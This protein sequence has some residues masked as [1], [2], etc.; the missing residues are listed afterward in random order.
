MSGA[1]ASTLADAAVN[2]GAGASGSEDAH[3]PMNIKI[4]VTEIRPIIVSSKPGGE[5]GFGLWLHEDPR[6]RIVA[7]G[8]LT[9]LLA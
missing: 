9:A 5:P 8:T 7:I 4:A 1:T 2:A 6:L 3:V